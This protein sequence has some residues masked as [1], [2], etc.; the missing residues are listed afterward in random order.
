MK[1]LLSDIHQINKRSKLHDD[2][3]HKRQTNAVLKKDLIKLGFFSLKVYVACSL[4]LFAFPKFWPEYEQLARIPSMP[5]VIPVAQIGLMG[6][7]YCTI[8][9]TIERFLTVCHPF[10]PRR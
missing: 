3:L 10:L 8:A 1:Y 5:F 4:H 9:L 7:I 2:E 6:S